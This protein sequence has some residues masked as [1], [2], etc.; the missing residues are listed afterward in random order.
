MSCNTTDFNLCINQY[1][2]YT[3]NLHFT[4]SEG[5]FLDITD[6]QVS[7]SIKQKYKDT[8]SLVDFDVTTV[9]LPSA[10]INL[11]LTPA[12]TSLLTKQQYYYDVIAHVSGSDPDET[13]RLLEGTVTVDP[14]VTVGS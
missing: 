9:S 7:G 3:L 14:G 6:W 12:K 5:V 11:H 10:S 13:I 1:A 2:S 4:D 8:G